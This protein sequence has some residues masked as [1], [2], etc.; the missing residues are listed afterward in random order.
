[1][2]DLENDPDLSLD[3][4]SQKID[5][6]ISEDDLVLKEQVPEE[7]QEEL[8]EEEKSVQLNSPRPQG[9]MSYEEWTKAGRDPDEFKGSKAYEKDG[10]L[11]NSLIRQ[12]AEMKEMQN[13]IAKLVESHEKVSK[14]SYEKALDDLKKGM[15]QAAELADTETVLKLMDEH[16]KLLSSTESISRP[17][18]V[19]AEAPQDT[20][21]PEVMY[22]QERNNSWY[23]RA[24]SRDKVD[25]TSYANALSS[26]LAKEKPGLTWSQHLTIVEENVKSNFPSLF[27]R[28][29][30]SVN[31]VTTNVKEAD[32]RVK[33]ES[34]QNLFQKL[35][36]LHKKIVRNI[37][38]GPSGKTFNIKKYIEQ[39]KD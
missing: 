25:A 14:N 15:K 22:F 8:K 26:Q 31:K 37:M 6:I 18:E 34:D 36:D 29:V 11:Y 1:M 20:R 19:K 21:P 2:S 30:S 10:E 39:L 9:H 12:Q 3:E 13:I 27:N 16:T 24:D 23:G 17:K 28:G 38:N 35:P 7:K 4:D 32:S 33:D 5:E